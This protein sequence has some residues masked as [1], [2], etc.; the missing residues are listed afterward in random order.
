MKINPSIE[1]VCKLFGQ[2]MNLP[3][4][5]PG[6]CYLSGHLSAECRLSNNGQYISLILCF[7]SDPPWSIIFQK[8]VLIIQRYIPGNIK[9][10]VLRY[11]TIT[12]NSPHNGQ[13]KNHCSLEWLKGHISNKNQWSGMK[14]QYAHLGL[15][16]IIVCQQTWS[17][18]VLQCRQT[19]LI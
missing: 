14:W 8:D 17:L 7:I 19:F 16:L 13:C 2:Q 3:S 4:S 12:W 10:L 1:F 5:W 18:A 6:Y 11:Y 15:V 9:L